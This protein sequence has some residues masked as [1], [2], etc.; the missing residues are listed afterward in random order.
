METQMSRQEQQELIP[1]MQEVVDQIKEYF[2]DKI[3]ELKVFDNISFN[4]YARIRFF[5]EYYFNMYMEVKVHSGGYGRGKTHARVHLYDKS[6][7]VSWQ[8][9]E[10]GKDY[11]GWFD[12]VVSPL[13]ND[14]K[15]RIKLEKELNEVVS[16]AKREIKELGLEK[17]YWNQ[18]G[19]ATATAIGDTPLIKY[20]FKHRFYNGEDK[21]AM[22]MQDLIDLMMRSAISGEIKVEFT[23][24]VGHDALML[25]KFD[26]KYS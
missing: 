25:S 8:S 19:N 2:G 26:K 5:E 9:V 24:N 22:M 6:K 16:V 21:N 4:T 15:E 3:F 10:V 7:Q 11:F 1:V 23:V 14:T 12:E 17:D 18:K 13:Y 20:E